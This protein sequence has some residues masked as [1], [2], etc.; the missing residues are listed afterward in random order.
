VAD[1][2]S[3]LLPSFSLPSF[4]I[5][6]PFFFRSSLHFILFHASLLL[7]QEQSWSWSYGSWIYNYLCNQRLSPLR[8]WVRTS[9]RGEVFDTTLCD[10][11]YQWLATGRWFSPSNLVSS[12]NKTYNHDIAEILLKVTLTT[13]NQ[14]SP[15]HRPPPS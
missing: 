8:L 6:L 14:L 2:P 3:V 5:S 13:I 15:V 12:T 9:L 4:P 10:K 11:V 7:S 1:W